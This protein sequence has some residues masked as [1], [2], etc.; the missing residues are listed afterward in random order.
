M[1]LKMA[2]KGDVAKIRRHVP[3]S[4]PQTL[5][6]PAAEAAGLTAAQLEQ[7][8]VDAEEKRK[9]ESKKRQEA[10]AKEREA[11]NKERAEEKKKRKARKVAMFK[12]FAERRAKHEKANQ[13]KPDKPEK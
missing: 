6:M 1:S 3:G 7:R 8:I 12:K 2:I 10:R 9:A 13:P 11:L 5:T 4:R